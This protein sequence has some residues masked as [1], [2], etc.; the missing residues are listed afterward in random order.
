MDANA[1]L[2]FL[3]S[4]PG[5]ANIRALFRSAENG[6]CSL[7]IHAV[8]AYEVYYQFY[9]DIRFYWL[10]HSYL[11]QQSLP[12]IIMNLTLLNKPVQ[13]HFTGIDETDHHKKL[14]ASCSR[15]GNRVC[16]CYESNDFSA[17]GCSDR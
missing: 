6:N 8:N 12:P 2:A 10:R 11:A 3:G 15:A 16:L 13:L 5:V 14:F 17:T 1:I 4:E 9:R 7:Y